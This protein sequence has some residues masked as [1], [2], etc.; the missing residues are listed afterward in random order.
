MAEEMKKMGNEFGLAFGLAFLMM[1]IILAALYE[2]LL[3]P[4]IIMVA[5]PMSFIGVLLALLLAGKSFNLFTMMGIIL[6]MGMVGKNAVL[7]VDFA[8][9]RL[10]KGATVS[11]A[12]I[13]AGEKRLRPI[14]MTTF[15]MVFAMLPL[16]LMKGAGYESNSPM[17]TAVVGGLIS[18][19]LLTLIVVPS[20]YKFL[21][22]LDLWMRKFYDLDFMKVKENVSEKD[23]SKAAGISEPK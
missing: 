2:S 11:E 22:P 4:L 8:N 5:L 14:L 7:L 15:A 16:V 21:S 23:E 12:L 17:A 3:Q 9:Q 6:L 18:S 20:I 19:M 1:Y 13:L 10:R